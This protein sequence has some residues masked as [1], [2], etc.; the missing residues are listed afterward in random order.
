MNQ[1]MNISRPQNSVLL[2]MR[3]V[4]P[5]IVA[6]ADEIEAGTRVPQDLLN[7]MVEAGC[8]R[9]CLPARF[10]GEE[11]SLREACEVI[12]ET[13]MADA[14]CA[15]HLMVAAG[16]QVIT[17]R[18][19]AATLEKYYAG[20]PDTWPKGAFTPKA[21][22]VPVEGGYRLSGRW[23]LASGSREDYQWVCLG[24]MVKDGDGIKMSP[25]GKVPDIRIC[26]IPREGVKVIETWDAVGLRG[27]RSDDLEVKDVF[28][29]EDWQANFFAASN[30]PDAMIGTKMP[31]ATAPHHNAVVNGILRGAVADITTAAQT[32]RPAFNPRMVMKDDPTFKTR[33]GEIVA[34]VDALRA[35]SEGCIDILENCFR[36]RRDPTALEGAR[37]G[38]WQTLI[39]HEGTSLLDQMM[40]LSGSGAVYMSNTLQR[41]WRDLRCA[42]QHQSANIGNFD[43]YSTVLT[44][45]AAQ[46]AQAA[47]PLASAA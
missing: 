44:N 30:I 46:Q 22:A 11:L 18:L 41:R 29:P 12:E 5:E 16:S 7:K 17:A 25:D 32:R 14:S 37:L 45:E 3:D 33:F 23:P 31:F 15:W 6:R 19:P 24:F 39:H 42:A 26:V 2:K 13:A 21:V 34:K 10:G 4:I 38:V 28:V 1:T 43:K 27:T 20:G 40:M 47:T 9:M 8:F 35:L 36:E